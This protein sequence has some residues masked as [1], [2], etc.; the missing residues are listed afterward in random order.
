MSVELPA[1]VRARVRR[2]EELR[3]GRRRTVLVPY[4]VSEAE[5]RHA[6]MTVELLHEW[7]KQRA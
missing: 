1:H 2:A 3:K 4:K 6:A 7:L 5:R